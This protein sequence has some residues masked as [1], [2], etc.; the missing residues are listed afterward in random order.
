MPKKSDVGQ[1]LKDRGIKKTILAKYL[2]MSRQGLEYHIKGDAEIDKEIYQKMLEFLGEKRIKEP[3]ESY[4]PELENRVKEL[5]KLVTI[6]VE[7]NLK[8]E[9]ENKK[10]SDEI[11]Q[12]NKSAEEIDGYNKL[13]KK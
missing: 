13:K 9:K 7:K 4:S 10:L 12:I 1:L 11:A 8:L 2:G 3:I 6:L 5:E